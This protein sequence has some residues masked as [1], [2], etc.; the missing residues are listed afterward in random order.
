MWS[1]RGIPE[2]FPPARQIR[3]LHPLEHAP[4]G[5]TAKKPMK[6]QQ[7]YFTGFLVGV[8]G[9]E[10]VYISLITRINTAFLMLRDKFHD[11]F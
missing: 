2:R 6:H 3:N 8:T 11:K 9:F 4:A 10:P 5:R 1:D 7:W